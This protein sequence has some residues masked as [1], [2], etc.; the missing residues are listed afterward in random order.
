MGVSDYSILR[1]RFVLTGFLA[2]LPLIFLTHVFL[3]AILALAGAVG[4]QPTAKR[5]GRWWPRIAASVRSEL[6]AFLL[7]LSFLF[8]LL[9]ARNIDI[10]TNSSVE[11][12]FYV[13]LAFPLFSQVILVSLVNSGWR[14]DS[15]AFKPNMIQKL[16]FIV[17]S[18]LVAGLYLFCTLTSSHRPST[19]LF[20]NN[21][22]GA[23]LRKLGSCCL[24]NRW[25]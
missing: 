23:D 11:I 4:R 25:S 24:G 10:R 7:V 3:L 2:I 5:G 20:P 8:T 17:D 12:M 22:A 21:S 9:A 18:I 1:T 6:A 14:R 15:R 19:P 13:G 16:A